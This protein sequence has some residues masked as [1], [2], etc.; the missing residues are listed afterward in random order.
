[1]HV[2]KAKWLVYLATFV[3]LS[4]FGRLSWW[5]WHKA[6]ELETQ[7]ARQAV[8][9]QESPLIIG[10]TLLDEQDAKGRMAQV[11]GHFETEGQFFLDNQQHLG[12]P[13]VHV[14]TP[15][16]IEDSHVRLW[17]NR[18]WVGWSRGRDALPQVL[19][20]EGS[21]QLT[22]RLVLPN[23]KPLAFVTPSPDD[24]ALRV[25]IHLQELRKQSL[26]PV[27]PLVMQLLT[28]E[29]AD[30]LVRDWPVPENKVPM[31]KGY[32]IQWA[33]MAVVA[34]FF[35]IRSHRQSR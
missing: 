23:D 30:T 4:V 34:L 1:M 11:R 31:H 28:S 13:G 16:V 21:V 20:P 25:Q 5:Q 9:D 10:S 17:V 32:A 2:L 22:G 8:I 27:Q 33:L 26:H 29:P 14:L 7:L 3:L 35:F 24:G 12:A 15:F 6:V 19:P 18:G